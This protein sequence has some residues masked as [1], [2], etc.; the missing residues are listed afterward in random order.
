[1]FTCGVI[2]LEKVQTLLSPST[3]GLIVLLLLF[4]RNGFGIKLPTMVDMLL[5]KNII[6]YI[7][8]VKL[9]HCRAFKKVGDND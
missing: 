5:N 7:F 8:F 4:F 2:D 3:M 9:L 1:M 6:Y